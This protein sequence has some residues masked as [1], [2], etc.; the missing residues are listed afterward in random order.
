MLNGF[1][2]TVYGGVAIYTLLCVLFVTFAGLLLAV[3]D[4]W[5]LVKK[6]KNRE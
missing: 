4:I 6:Y 3:Q 5:G 2:F 1:Q